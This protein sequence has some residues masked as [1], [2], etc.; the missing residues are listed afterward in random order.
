M[1]L[2]LVMC[3]MACCVSVFKIVVCYDCG[4]ANSGIVALQTV[5]IQESA[6]SAVVGPPLYIFSHTLPLPMVLSVCACTWTA[7]ILYCV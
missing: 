6:C 5:C 1:G 2:S 4:V 3:V 7:D